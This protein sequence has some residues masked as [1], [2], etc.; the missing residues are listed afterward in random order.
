MGFMQFWR[1]PA[2]DREVLMLFKSPRPIQS[3]DVFSNA[4]VHGALHDVAVERRRPILI[5]GTQP[6]TYIEARGHSA[7]GGDERVE[8]VTTNVAGT[9]YFG[10]YVRP[11]EA[12]PNPMA[13]AALRE[14]CPKP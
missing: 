2:D 8:M 6:A 13:A 9:S 12:L 1:P 3:G 14:I 10:L 4:Q 7:R 11:I 5:C